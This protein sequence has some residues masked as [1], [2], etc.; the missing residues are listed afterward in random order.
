ME[1]NS[2][3]DVIF[4]NYKYII[5]KNKG[6]FNLYNLLHNSNKILSDKEFHNFL[7]EIKREERRD[8]EYQRYLSEQ[9]QIKKF[10][11]IKF[12]KWKKFQGELIYKSKSFTLT[13]DKD[14]GIYIKHSNGKS[15][16]AVI[17]KYS[18][19]LGDMESYG[20]KDIL[21]E[22]KFRKFTGKK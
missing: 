6:F 8:R 5:T 11:K 18:A 10:N 17:L 19:L 22:K 2:K 20:C 13:L 12:N 9:K 21:S 4:S 14:G 1:F 15:N 7:L 16:A 3:M